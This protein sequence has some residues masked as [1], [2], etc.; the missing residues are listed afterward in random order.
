MKQKTKIS[1]D[2]NDII[3]EKDVTVTTKEREKLTRIMVANASRLSSIEADLGICVSI[4]Q[5]NKTDPDVFKFIRRSTYP[6]YKD[7]FD[8]FEAAIKQFMEW[9]IKQTA[10]EP[11][12]NNQQKILKK[13]YAAQLVWATTLVA[14]CNDMKEILDEIEKYEK[15]ESG[16]PTDKKEMS[17]R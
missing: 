14:L 7:D 1:C 11:N 5:K 6:V 15:N 13:C 10:N 16:V 17:N 2:H 12:N 8:S 3:F 9:F 4:I